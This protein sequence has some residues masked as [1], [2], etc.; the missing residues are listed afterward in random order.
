MTHE[1]KS[2][3]CSA[4]AGL[5][6]E[7]VNQGYKAFA[8]SLK[9]ETNITMAIANSLWYR[10]GLE[11]KPGFVA[12]NQKFYG[13]ALDALDFSS[14][15]A[16]GRINDWAADATH[17][18]IKQIIQPPISDDARVILANAIYFKGKWQNQ[19]D[20]KLTRQRP[21]HLPDGSEK[22]VSMMQQHRKM[23]YQKG[24]AYQAV[25]LTYEGGDLEMFVFL[26]DT[27]SDVG[28]L[29]AMF[30]STAWTRIAAG[31][32][33][34]EGT[35]ELPRF[36]LECGTKLNDPLQAMGIKRAFSRDAD[37]SEMA[38]QSLFL[39]EVKQKSFVAVNEE[40]TE[41]AAVT[42]GQMHATA[43]MIPEEPFQMTVDRPFVFLIC[44]NAAGNHSILFAGIVFE[45]KDTPAS[46]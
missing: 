7:Q 45:P 14:P 4:R 13:A 37:F 18:R 23:A 26:P 15:A 30:D 20:K 41:A 16:A 25:R 28:K 32:R 34:R 5:S 40:G 24:D 35:L 19:F 2:N 10:Q 11:L 31:F 17:D 36:T 22:Q 33:Q 46:E 38:E 21:F 27:D 39:S 29:I 1:K 44:D 9:S 6:R 3:R 8:E 12:C 42:T 43:V